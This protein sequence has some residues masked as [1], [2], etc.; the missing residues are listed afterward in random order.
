MRSNYSVT[1]P[2]PI[3]EDFVRDT[4]TKVGALAAT[5]IDSDKFTDDEKRQ[6]FLNAKSVID[7]IA[8]YVARYDLESPDLVWLNKSLL[9]MRQMLVERGL[10]ADTD[11]DEHGGFA[12]W[13]G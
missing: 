11:S 6:A 2:S 13:C 5:I 1:M 8:R 7:D 4:A 3:P 12:P 10:L 9:V